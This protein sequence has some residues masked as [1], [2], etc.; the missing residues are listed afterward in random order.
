MKNIQYIGVI[1]ML[2]TLAADYSYSLDIMNLRDQ[3]TLMCRGGIVARGD[4]DLDVQRRCGE[5]LKI[6]SRQNFGPIW[7]YHFGQGRF[8]YYLAF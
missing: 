8:M 1:S 7:V 5:P 2:L 3:T 4:S 6:A